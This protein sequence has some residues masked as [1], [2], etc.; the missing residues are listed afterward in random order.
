V[1]GKLPSGSV[2]FSGALLASRR[3]DFSSTLSFIAVFGARLVYFTVTMAIL[4]TSIAIANFPQRV[5][6]FIHFPR[7]TED[8]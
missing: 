3:K 4:N 5:I 2:T 1:Q 8:P 7:N 6:N